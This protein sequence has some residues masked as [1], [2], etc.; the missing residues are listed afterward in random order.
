MPVGGVAKKRVNPTRFWARTG[1][2]D[3]LVIQ[4]LRTIGPVVEHRSG[5]AGGVPL[6]AAGHAGMAAGVEV[7]V[8][9]D[10]MASPLSTWSSAMRPR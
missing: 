10:A 5:L 8:E 6:L 1:L 7:E 3:D 2:A 9:V 4:I